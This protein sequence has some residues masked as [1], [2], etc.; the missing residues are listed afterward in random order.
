MVRDGPFGEQLMP[1]DSKAFAVV[2]HQLA[3]I[4]VKNP[5]DRS[6]VRRCVE[7][8]DGVAQVVDPVDIG[9]GHSR[10]GEWIALAQPNAW[11]HYYFWLDDARAPITRERW[12]FIASQ[13]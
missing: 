8:I 13:V 6:A 5:S 1:G 10:S 12:I 7:S 11:F 2:D 9:L 4:Y 3:H